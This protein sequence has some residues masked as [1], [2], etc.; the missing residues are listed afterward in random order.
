MS[1][2]GPLL[3][4]KKFTALIMLDRCP[5]RTFAASWARSAPRLA[6]AWI[7]F[8]WQRKEPRRHHLSKV[9]GVRSGYTRCLGGM[10]WSHLRL[11]CL[12]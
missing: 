12:P 1:E 3:R 6:T 10:L 8:V 4:A 9:T 5:L 2:A 7:A 11:D